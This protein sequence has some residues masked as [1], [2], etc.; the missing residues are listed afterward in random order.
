MLSLSCLARHGDVQAIFDAHL[1]SRLQ[2]AFGGLQSFLRGIAL[3]DGLGNLPTGDDIAAI[4]FIGGKSD[5]IGKSLHG[6][7]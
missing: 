1:D 3:G 6:D 4:H 7:S 2:S 5:G